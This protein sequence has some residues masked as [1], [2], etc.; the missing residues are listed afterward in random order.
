M[1]AHMASNAANSRDTK[2]RLMDAAFETLKE[3]GI[4]G[5]SA[6]AIAAQ[7]G[8]NQA[9]IFY[10]FGTVTN[11]LV[12]SSRAAT[13][14]RVAAFDSIA[15]NTESLDDLVETARRL[16]VDSMEDGSVAVLTQLMA[17]A[18]SDP[19]VAAAILDGFEDWISLVQRALESVLGDTPLREVISP[20]EAAYAISALFLGIQLM[21][22]LDPARSEAPAVFDALG[23]IATMLEAAL[24][25]LT[26]VKSE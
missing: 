9:L 16:H 5:A 24:P 19:N 14:D 21:E 22:R 6:R 15:A 8:F 3:D 7:G 18:G 13:K 4:T 10:H 20:R 11:L 1:T 17:G 26:E 12:E 23:R 2:Q 25:F